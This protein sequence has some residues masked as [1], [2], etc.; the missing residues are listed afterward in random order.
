MKKRKGCVKVYNLFFID[1]KFT[2][3]NKRDLKQDSSQSGFLWSNIPFDPKKMVVKGYLLL[4]QVSIAVPNPCIN[5]LSLFS[6]SFSS[7]F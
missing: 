5:L 7:Y 6:I 4:N 1:K 2:L 3:K